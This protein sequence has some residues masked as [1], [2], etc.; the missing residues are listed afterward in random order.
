M[1][2]SVLF[3]AWTSFCAS[4]AVAQETKPPAPTTPKISYDE[5]VRPI[6]RE[7]C[8]SCHSADK[9]E[10]GLQLDSYQKAMAGGS[11]GEV[12]L[13]GDLASSRLWAL[14]SHAEEPKMPPKQDKLAA[15]KLDVIS[16]WIEQGAPENAGSKVTLKKNPLAAVAGATGG[17]PEGPAAMPAGLL[18]QPVL[19]TKRPGQITALAASPWAPL[20]AVAGQKQVALYHSDSGELL[21]ILPFPE[22]IPHVIRFSRN[23]S[24][25]LVA[26]GRG[27][28]SG[29]V[30]LYDVKTGKRIAK[31]GDELDAVLAADINASQTLVAL[32]G[33][34]RV[35]R[36]FSAQTGELMHEI[37]KHTD[38]IY[39]MEFSPDGKSLT[40]ADRSGGL[41]VWEADTARESLFL[42]G[43]TGG[44]TD[45]DWRHDSAIFASAGDDGT[46]K[47]WDVNEGKAAKSW[48]AHKGGAFCVRFA[49]DGRLVSSGR[50]NTVKTWAADGAAQKSFPAFNEP[51]LRC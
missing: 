9:Q 23:G 10:S 15:A 19:Y 39:A 50:D 34:N 44:V 30:V 29:C 22:G 8:F 28:H 46:V 17:K 5:H 49:H 16:K 2:H 41:F 1:R 35:V 4:F 6:L 43:H 40:T 51:A 42:R 31:I 33:P 13:P 11:S 3:I 14:V 20:V 45:I 48:E 25:V 27:G 36:I 26:G 37:R 7:H 47:L 38:W 32:G 18:K 21:G 24:V 12:V